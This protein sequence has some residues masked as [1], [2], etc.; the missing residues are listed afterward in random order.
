MG[1]LTKARMPASLL[2][3]KDL[4]IAILVLQSI[5]GVWMVM[6]LRDMQARQN[7]FET[8]LLA[9][10]RKMLSESR[11]SAVAAP[12][13]LAVP[14]QTVQKRQNA[15]QASVSLPPV[16][17]G[18]PTGPAQVALTEPVRSVEN[19]IRAMYDGAE[20]HGVK[21]SEIQKNGLPTMKFSAYTRQLAWAD[22]YLAYKDHS[23]IVNLVLTDA[24]LEKM[25]DDPLYATL[26]AI[27][28]K[29]QDDRT[30]QALAATGCPAPG[31]S[32]K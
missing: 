30:L 7:T 22:F 5:L 1:R 19:C 31:N 28:E 15:S 18:A 9:T 3:T 16:S 29:K 17:N 6:Q 8:D 21:I 25:K 32:P 26:K 14:A 13:P 23:N 27:A 10:V 2:S 24:A 11:P 12:Y 20:A 4:L